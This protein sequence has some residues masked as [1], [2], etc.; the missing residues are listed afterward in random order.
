MNVEKRLE[1]MARAVAELKSLL[2]PGLLGN[3]SWFEAVEVVATRPH[4]SG[5]DFHARNVFSVYVAEAGARPK[6]KKQIFLNKPWRLKGIPEW[7]FGITRRPVGVSEIIES[8]ERYGRQGVWMPPG[9]P[10]LEV[11]TLTAAPAMFCPS[12]SRTEVP[13]KVF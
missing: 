10:L 12:D 4:E 13:L 6:A 3:Y 2:E 5:D 7:G 1:N 11:G 9:Q 8:I